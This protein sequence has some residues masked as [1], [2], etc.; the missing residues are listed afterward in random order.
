MNKKFV[1][2]LFVF[3]LCLSFLMNMAVSIPVQAQAPVSTPTPLPTPT[4]VPV[5]VYTDP[6]IVTFSQLKQSEFELI[7]PFDSNGF[8]FAIPA[9]WSL[10][11]GAALTLSLA[12]SFNSLIQTQLN[13]QVVYG[14]GTLTVSLNNKTLDVLQLNQVGETEANISIPP[15]DF[16]STDPSGRMQLNIV[17]SSQ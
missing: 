14:G 13:S 11:T 9:D 5:I 15:E 10:K 1:F 12:V 16:V 2:R 3:I 6:N 17:L 7:G 8:S 4:Q